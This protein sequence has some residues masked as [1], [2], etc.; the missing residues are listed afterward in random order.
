MSYTSD[1]QDHIRSYIVNDVCIHNPENIKD[2]ECVT[3]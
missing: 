2:W 1:G 3:K